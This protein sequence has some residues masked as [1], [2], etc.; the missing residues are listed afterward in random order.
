MPGGGRSLEG[1]SSSRVAMEER[2]KRLSRRKEGEKE[3]L[4][5]RRRGHEGVGRGVQ[6]RSSCRSRCEATEADVDLK[7][8]RDEQ[9][10]DLPPKI[11]DGGLCSPPCWYSSW[12]C[13][14]HCATGVACLGINVAK[15]FA[16][17][18]LCGFCYISVMA[19]PQGCRASY[20]QAHSLK[21]AVAIKPLTLHPK[22]FDIDKCLKSVTNHHQPILSL[23]LIISVHVHNKVIV[24]TTPEMGDL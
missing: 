2:G 7:A 11:Q 10:P 16:N 20:M 1:R 4:R 12:C 22:R 17:V 21:A 14:P 13:F 8:V 23:F 24:K 18:K 15:Q 19:D 6:S 9:Q 5:R 3:I